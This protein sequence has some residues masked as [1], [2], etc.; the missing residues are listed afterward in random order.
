[1]Y[2]YSMSCTYVQ[3]TSY[4]YYRG[5]I[6]VTSVINR[7]KRISYSLKTNVT[8]VHRDSNHL[9]LLIS[10]GCS[11]FNSCKATPS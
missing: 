6:I 8:A 9:V 4:S 11:Q 10:V 5:S 7:K 2:H 3:M 1:M